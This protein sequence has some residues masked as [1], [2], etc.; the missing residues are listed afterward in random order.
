MS[1]YVT[2]AQIEEAAHRVAGVVTRT[3]LLP[4]TGAASGQ[5]R[6]LLKPESLQPTGAFKLRGAYNALRVLATGRLRGVVAHSSGNHARAVAYAARALGVPAILV[7]P[8]SAPDIKIEAC[9]DLGADIVFVEP[10]IE[11]RV[12]TAQRL[13]SAHGYALVP[14]FDDPHVI[15]GQ[16]TV[17]LEI[18]DDAP[19]VGTILVPVSGGGLI[20]GIAVA[21]RSRRKDVRIIGVEP[22]LAADARDSLRRGYRV[23]WP[24]E[25]VSRTIAD[26]LRVER[27][28]EL[29]FS[30]M[31]KY[32]DDIVTVSDAEIRAAMRVLALDA[33][34]VAEPAGAASTAAYLFHGA[35]LPPG[36]TT[37]AV[38]SGGGVDPRLL[39]EVLLRPPLE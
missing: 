35:E 28:G 17:G 15:A 2:P 1:D 13:A 8:T 38:L 18:L 12:E 16:G 34:L 27:L 36:R 29:T 25:S 14:P 9:R 22:E 24:A 39:A 3:P 19:E 10:L 30:H 5:R 32:V 20:S 33:R 23:A 4:L 6:L 31:S 21:A 37:V 26:A 7:M 11:A